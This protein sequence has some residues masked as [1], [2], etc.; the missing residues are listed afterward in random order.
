MSLTY[1]RKKE[2]LSNIVIV[3]FIALVGITAFLSNAL[4]TPIKK[5]S[6]LVDQ[7]KLFNQ[8]E[9]ESIIRISLKNKSGEYI[10]ER[11]DKNPDS[12]WHMVSPQNI[13]ANSIFIEKLFSS[14]NIIKTKKM[15]AN[16]PTNISN[17]SLDKPTAILTLTD[18]LGKKI[19]LQVGIMNTIDNSTYLKVSEKT[20]IFHVEAPTI[21]LENTTLADLIESKIFEVDI[22]TIISFKLYK[23][24]SLTAQFEIAKKNNEW[25]SPNDRKL[26]PIRLED[27]LNDFFKLKSTFVLDKPSEA[28]KK[29]L[30]TLEKNPNYILRMLKS[31]SEQL[32]YTISEPITSLV[33]V[34]LKN[35]AHFII[36][37][38]ISSNIYIVKADALNLFEIK[39][40]ILKSLEQP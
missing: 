17:F 10:F 36:S 30:N 12:A 3:F 38:N 24:L 20:E 22:K 37:T 15:L 9:L 14:L 23:R 18:D 21:S 35:E 4:Q 39:N 26:D 8:K 40:D 34:D 2:I 19:I 25:I 32:T 28:Q 33:D 6:E 27:I 16:T 11:V 29:Q 13:F 7:A 1:N 5:N 31:D